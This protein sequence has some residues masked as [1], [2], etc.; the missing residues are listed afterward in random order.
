M[1]GEYDKI[2]HK[3][4]I[5]FLFICLLL[6]PAAAFAEE[7]TYD[8]KTTDVVS[9]TITTEDNIEREVNPNTELESSTIENAKVSADDIDTCTFEWEANGQEVTLRYLYEGTDE[10]VKTR[11]SSY[12]LTDIPFNTTVKAVLTTDTEHEPV[13]LICNPS[14]QFKPSGIKNIPVKSFRRAND[15]KGYYCDKIEVYDK[16]GEKICPLYYSFK[17]AESINS[18]GEYTLRVVFEGKYKEYKPLSFNI[19]VIPEVPTVIKRSTYGNET[20]V[21]LLSKIYH[22]LCDYYVADISTNSNFSNPVTVK[23]KSRRN[24]AFTKIHFR[25]LK[26][27]SIYHVRVRAVKK[28]NNK[29]LYSNP[30][31]L[32]VRTKKSM[33]EYSRN[34]R[35]VRNIVSLMKKN[36]DFVYTFNQNYS[37]TKIRNFMSHIRND[38]PQY[39]NRYYKETMFYEDYAEIRYTPNQDMGRYT[40][41]TRV[42]DSIAKKAKTK[43]GVKAKVRYINKRMCRLCRYDYDTY[44]HNK[45]YNIYAYTLYGC[46]VRHKAVCMG[47]AEAFHAICVQSGIEDK[48]AYGKNHIWNKVKIGK[49]WLHVDVTWNDCTHSSRWLLKKKHKK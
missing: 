49:K 11:D 8:N 18:P 44:K 25:N 38:F 5:Y 15:R 34:Q 22:G 31:I 47:Y 36:K 28:Y 46:M 33:P 6:L 14:E 3:R 27:N 35:D 13:E 24:G 40:K 10:T 23:M 17:G 30:C 9:G 42:I 4:I 45:K 1:K 29:L 16:A 39:T 41:A 26:N 43:K 7:T 32:K 21:V 2:M 37:P 19:R 12:K 20:S 48:Y